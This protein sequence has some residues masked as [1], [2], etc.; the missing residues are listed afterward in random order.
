M[1]AADDDEFDPEEDDRVSVSLELTSRILSATH[2]TAVLG[3]KPDR[4]WN[5]GDRRRLVADE[6]H[7]KAFYEFSRWSLN[8]PLGR[9]S[10]DHEHLSALWAR[11]APTFERVTELRGSIDICLSFYRNLD[12]RAYQGHGFSVPDNWTKWLGEVGGIIDVD[13][14]VLRD[15][16]RAED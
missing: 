9:C 3:T 4:S 12:G 14:Y 8:S 11:C 1:I 6:T 13:Q 16:P 7:P 5:I 15:G 10:R 2:I